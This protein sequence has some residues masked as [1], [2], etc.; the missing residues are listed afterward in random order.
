MTEITENIGATENFGV[1]FEVFANIINKKDFSWDISGNF[2][3]IENKITELYG[4]GQ[5]D[6]L[7]RWFIG[8]PIR[9]NFA[10]EYGGVYQIGD[11]FDNSPIPDAEPGFAKVVD[12]DGDGDIDSDDRIIIGQRDPKLIAGFNMTFAYKNFSLNIVSQGAFGVTRENSLLDDN[13]FGDV[14]RNTTKKNWWTPDNPT[15]DFY[16]NSV[17]AN[18]RGVNIY[19]SADYWRVRDITL[20]YNMPKSVTDAIGLNGLRVYFSGRNLFTIT[21]FGGLDPEFSND[22]DIPLPKTYTVGLNLSL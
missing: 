12:Q 17:D 2:S 22:R 3:Y 20:S 6:V 4:N 14:R 13:V 8:Q 7:N 18:P 5:D 21:N 10:Y 9:V 15:N 11:D 19:E 16:A 1:D